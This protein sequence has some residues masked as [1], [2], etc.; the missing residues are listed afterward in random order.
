MPAVALTQVVVDQV[1]D[2]QFLPT[3]DKACLLAAARYALTSSAPSIKR[4]WGGGAALK[5]ISRVQLQH[6]SWGGSP[7]EGG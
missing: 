7:G 1:P 3:E 6:D 2:L 4:F 5:G